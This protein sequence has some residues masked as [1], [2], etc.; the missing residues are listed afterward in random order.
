MNIFRKKQIKNMAQPTNPDSSNLNA[1]NDNTIEFL[2]NLNKDIE[3]IIDQHNS[4]NSE[5]DV[6]A[7]LA[8][9]IKKEMETA[10]NLTITTEHST[11]Q[12][13]S[14]GEN[15]IYMTEENVKKSKDG[16]KILED[17]IRIILSL[18]DE[19]KNTYNSITNLWSM[20]QQITQVAKIIDGIASQTNMLALNAAIEAAD[21]VLMTDE[22]SKLNKAIEIEEKIWYTVYVIK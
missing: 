12:L 9:K 7:Q 6:L 18:E 1:Y 15:L 13:H 21:I 3:R 20:I 19:A 5:H 17:I 16:K 14:Q 2:K 22:I 8:S 10:S 4:V 11:M